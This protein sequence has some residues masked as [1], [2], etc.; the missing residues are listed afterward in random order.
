MKRF[1]SAALALCLLCPPLRAAAAP[2]LSAASAILV[3]ADSGRVLYERDAHTRR[4]I[5]STT[6]LMTALVVLEG[7]PDLARTVTI[8]REDTLTEG[9]SMY[10][11]VGEEV[12]LECLLYGLLLHSGNDAALALARCTA[13]DVPAFVARMNQKARTLGMENTSFA[14]PNGLDDA[15]HYSTAAD[16]ALLARACLENETLAA[17]VA[18]RSITIGG[19][20]FTNHNKLL[21]RYEGCR[22][23]KT[24][25]T[26][27]AG[28][29]LVSCAS[30]DGQ[31]L[32]CVTLNAPDDWRDHTALYDYGF[33]HFPNQTLVRQGEVQDRIPVEGSLVRFAEVQAGGSFSYPTAEGEQIQR[34]VT[35]TQRVQAP[36][37]AGQ[38]AGMLTY[39]LEGQTI[40]E[41]PLVFAHSVP[42]D[43][44]PP[45]TW[46]QRLLDWLPGGREETLLPA[47]SQYRY[48]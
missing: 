1:L 32:V 46:F 47:F 39:R 41:V 24:G 33:S 21:S 14:N 35:L 30:R 7:A 18:T 36:V 29:T 26:Q 22:G 6:K 16:M 2:G 3:D 23:M 43:A 10:L 38:T 17:M 28:R 34:E 12:T 19:R 42:I 40:G 8:C 9:S 45:Q 15:A 11:R 27:F 25:Y 48:F 20:T 31:T 37:E 5:A 4:S 44:A 13:G